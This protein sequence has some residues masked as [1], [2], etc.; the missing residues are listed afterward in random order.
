MTSRLSSLASPLIHQSGTPGTFVWLLASTPDISAAT[1]FYC[2][3]FGWTTQP[4]PVGVTAYT[5]QG[6]TLGTFL[7]HI[8]IGGSSTRPGWLPFVRVR[9]VDRSTARAV[10][11]GGKILVS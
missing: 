7:T 10:A 8:N 3:L 6:N 11:A 1:T 4:A 9:D 5:A 2:R